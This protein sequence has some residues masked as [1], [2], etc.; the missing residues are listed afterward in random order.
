MLLVRLVGVCK[1]SSTT[2]GE[3]GHPNLALGGNRYGIPKSNIFAGSSAALLVLQM[4]SS[5]ITVIN[6][7]LQV[8][9]AVS[10]LI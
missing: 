4:T 1:K 10:C 9:K 2:C 6:T 8:S 7:D 3:Q 5:G